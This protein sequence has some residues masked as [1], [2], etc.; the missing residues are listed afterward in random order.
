MAMS[1]KQQPLGKR[2]IKGVRRPL[3]DADRERYRRMRERLEGEKQTILAK[4]RRYRREHDEALA[5]L[6]E[7][8]QV[9]KQAL[10]QRGLSLADVRERS[11]L[12]RSA[13]SRLENDLGANPTLATMIRFAQAVGKRIVIKLVDT[14]EPPAKGANVTAARAKS[15]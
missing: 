11:G 8:V 2:Q 9:L 10:H 15:R 5:E 4:G 7:V 1:R 3:S 14:D 6:R 13:V 12:E